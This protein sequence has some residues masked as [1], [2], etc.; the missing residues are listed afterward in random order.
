MRLSSSLGA[1]A[2]LALA[3]LAGCRTVPPP[4][5]PDSAPWA[6]RRPQLQALNHFELKGRVAL[7][8]A[9]N[10]VNANLRWSQQGTRSQLALE[11]PLGVGGTQVT[12]NGDQLDIVNSRG[13]HV[14]SE[15]AHAELRSRLG[16]DL[17]L[18]SLR[19]WILG[20]PDPATAAEESLQPGAQRLAA[21][22][23]DGWHVAYGDYTT[24]SGE[25]LPARLTLERDTVRVRLLVEDWQ[26]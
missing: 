9:G 24:V 17:P 15:A 1:S 7:S 12:A 10:G 13:E 5:L 22:T 20:V 19:Y 18:T 8:A 6:Q 4:A 23:Q 11:G 26:L 16:F 3:M 25:T 14:T 2:V 21:L